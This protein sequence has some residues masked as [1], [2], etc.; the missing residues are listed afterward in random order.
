MV[1]VGKELELRENFPKFPAQERKKEW[2][3]TEV[4]R[5]LSSENQAN[6]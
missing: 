6:S 1:D 3:E 5:D 2:R 4:P